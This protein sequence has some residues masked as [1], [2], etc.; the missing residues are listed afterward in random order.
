MVYLFLNLFFSG[1]CQQCY[2]NTEWIGDYSLQ[3]QIHSNENTI[4]QFSKLSIEEN[5]I[6]ILGE[7]YRRTDNGKIILIE[8]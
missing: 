3:Q 5:S 1:H 8:R 2:F 6:S 7:C 4:P